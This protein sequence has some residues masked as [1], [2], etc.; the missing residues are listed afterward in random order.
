MIKQLNPEAYY[1]QRVRVYRNLNNGLVSVLSCTK[2]GWK[3]AGH[4]DTLVID[5]VDYLVY[6]KARLKMVAEK[7]RA[8]HAYAEGTLTPKFPNPLPTHPLGYNPYRG[9][10]FID[11]A[12][13]EAVTQSQHL[14]VHNNIFLISRPQQVTQLTLF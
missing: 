4:T 8:V 11:K 2:T 3:L 10:S 9:G 14:V 6:E 7:Q 12:T 13:G 1:G 5:D